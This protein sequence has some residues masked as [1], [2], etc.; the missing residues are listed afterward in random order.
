M[1][2]NEEEI[3]KTIRGQDDRTTRVSDQGCFHISN[4]N[5]IY[6]FSLGCDIH[7]KGE[8]HSPLQLR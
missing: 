4:K 7:R 3:R 1:R 5:T 8:C 2:Y 6:R